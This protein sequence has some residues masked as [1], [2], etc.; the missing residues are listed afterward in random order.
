[1]SA[2]LNSAGSWVGVAISRTEI[3]AYDTRL[4]SAGSSVWRAPLE[5]PA[6]DQPSWISLTTALR[7]LAQLTRETKGHL[8]VALLPSIAEVRR[9]DVP[10]LSDD[11]LEAVLSRSATRYFVGAQGA[12]LVG[13]VA[14]GKADASGVVAGAAPAWIIRLITT[15]G[16]DSG[17]SL[18]LIAPAEAAWT[19]A[20]SDAWPTAAASNAQLLVHQGD[21]THALSINN[22]VFDNVRKFRSNV[23]DAAVF[24]ESASTSS[25]LLAMGEPT[26]RK[27]WST[28]LG[29]RALAVTLPTNVS[30]D[31]ASDP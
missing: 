27:G 23:A 6:A 17:W 22:G 1:M 8:T 4:R 21:Q 2:A 3:V 12:Q 18:E 19:V 16:R 31:V 10:P 11:E 20:A 7:S 15:A 30:A 28:A 9:V 5:T 13:V 24:M 29:A 25:R 14:R 26:V